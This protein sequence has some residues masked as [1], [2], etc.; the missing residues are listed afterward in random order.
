MHLYWM[1][2][3]NML[4]PYVNSAKLLNFST[5]LIVLKSNNGKSSSNHMIKIRFINVEMWS[6]EHNFV[7][8]SSTGLVQSGLR[9]EESEFLA[10]PPRPQEV[11]S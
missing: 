9:S 11:L 1:I 8:Y 10:A 2:V 5:M 3:G 7:W 4:I 6:L